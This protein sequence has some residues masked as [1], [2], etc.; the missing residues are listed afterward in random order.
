MSLE[1]DRCPFCGGHGQLRKWNLLG[2]DTRW[3]FVECDDCGAM[4]YP[5][6]HSIEMAVVK[7]NERPHKKRADQ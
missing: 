7:W 5:F 4:T 1:L 6:G 3:W 2:R